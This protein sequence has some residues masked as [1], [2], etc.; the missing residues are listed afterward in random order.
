M[1]R[2]SPTN[3]ITMKDSTSSATGTQFMVTRRWGTWPDSVAISHDQPCPSFGHSYSV[4]IMA[5]IDAIRE[6]N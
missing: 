2:V 5:Q 4:T 6:L 1:L 3:N